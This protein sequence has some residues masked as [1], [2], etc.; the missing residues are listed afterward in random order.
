MNGTWD[1][2]ASSNSGS[3]KLNSSG[4]YTLSVSFQKQ[5]YDGTNWV[6]ETSTKDTKSVSYKVVTSTT[7]SSTNKNTTNK[8]GVKT[9]DVNPIMLMV[10]L[11]VVSGAV[12]VV[13][14]VRTRSKRRQ[15][16]E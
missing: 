2:N 12:I 6:N 15:H 16:R 14:V 4:S 10:I 3:F 7:T 8:T 1:N 13:L 5:K 9:G 11:L